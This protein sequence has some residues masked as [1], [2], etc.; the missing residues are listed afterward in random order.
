MSA[1]E[2]FNE[3]DWAQLTGPDK[4]ALKVLA[5]VAID[6]EPLGKAPG[7]GQKSMDALLD[8]GLAIEGEPSLVQGRRFKLSKK[9]WLAVEWLQGRRTRVFPES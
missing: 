2:T 4:K 1:A 3:L 5:R 7:V 6:F 8:K 9:G